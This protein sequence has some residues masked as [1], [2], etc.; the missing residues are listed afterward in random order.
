MAFNTSL[1]T[2]NH[3][4][5]NSY[6]QDRTHVENV[7]ATTFLELQTMQIFKKNKEVRGICKNKECKHEI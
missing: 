1:S 6:N 7:L 3:R 4:Q 2:S 5:R